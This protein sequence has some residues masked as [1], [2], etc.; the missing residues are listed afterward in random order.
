MDVERDID[1]GLEVVVPAS[2]FD[3]DQRKT[4]DLPYLAVG[5]TTRAVND[6]ANTTLFVASTDTPDRAMDVVKQD[7]R[8]ADFNRNPVI[9]DNHDPR[10]VV[11]R[12]V[13][14]TVPKVGEDA[15]K[16]MIRVAWNVDS[17]N[18]AIAAVGLDHLNGFRHAGSV[19]FRSRK[20]T[21]RN[22]LPPEHPAYQEP[23]KIETWWGG[24]VEVA[25]NYYEGNT[26]L[27]FSSASLPMNP[28]A[29]QRSVGI[30]PVVLAEARQLTGD[31]DLLAAL[32]D[33]EIA[34]AVVRCLTPQFV[35]LLRSSS[36]IRRIVLAYEDAGPTRRAHRG[37]GLDFLFGVE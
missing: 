32:Q 7:W 6:E 35:E 33:P 4:V 27:E 16:L 28:E 9:F 20:T 1:W 14:A 2:Y 3:H 21:A 24:T 30:A 31:F 22:K 13:S 11:G 17:P 29:L 25:G 34:A 37:D 23:I 8:T 15:G 26:L 19:G 12:G 5:A 36:E 18:K 10:A